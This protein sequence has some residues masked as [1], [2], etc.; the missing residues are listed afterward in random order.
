M[1][2]HERSK[3]NESNKESGVQKHLFGNEHPGRH[4]IFLRESKH[5]K[6]PMINASEGFHD[7]GDLEKESNHVSE[8]TES[9]RESQ[10]KRALIMFIPFRSKQ[11]LLGSDNTYWSKF[12]CELDNNSGFFK[13]KGINILRNIQSSLSA[14]RLKRPPYNVCINIICKE[15][16][17]GSSKKSDKNEVYYG[18]HGFDEMT[19]GSSNDIEDDDTGYID[20]HTEIERRGK[21]NQYNLIEA[22][23][24]Q[25]NVIL[26]YD[27]N[28]YTKETDDQIH[29]SPQPAV[30]LDNF[31]SAIEIVK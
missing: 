23:F 8:H 15:A 13:Y 28:D 9:I 16:D 5:F 19:A 31:P 4:T 25:S 30:H 7:I 18:I 14:Q 3:L 21:I 26:D 29:P 27:S 11:H 12:K 1:M 17:K 2:K 22:P 10:A 6:V 20:R 24:I